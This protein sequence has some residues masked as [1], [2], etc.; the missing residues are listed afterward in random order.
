MNI[1]K[2]YIGK[3]SY[4]QKDCGSEKEVIVHSFLESWNF[5]KG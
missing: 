3:K 4:I 1:I 5:G 2:V